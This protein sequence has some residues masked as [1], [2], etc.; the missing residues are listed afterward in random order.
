MTDA[1]TKVVFRF[2]IDTAPG[3]RNGVPR[4]LDLLSE[5]GVPATFYANMGRAVSLRA[6]LRN[7]FSGEGGGAAATQGKLTAR[8]KIGL[9][10]VLETL[11]FNPLVGASYPKVLRRAASLGHEMGLHGGRS[12]GLWQWGAYGLSIDQLKSEIRWGIDQLN[13][14]VGACPQGFSSPGWASPET[15][16]GII[17]SF[18]FSY[19]ADMHD[20]EN[21]GVLRD[22]SSGILCL[23]TNL[24][25]E[26]RGVGF[27]E[28]V[29]ARDGDGAIVRDVL[30]E[31]LR[32]FEHVV[33]YDHP[34][35]SGGAGID[36]VRVAL[37][38]CSETNARVMTASEM[39]ADFAKGNSRDG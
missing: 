17:E 13:H 21:E 9:A 1:R 33:L 23:N 34:A 14:A 19:L 5:F 22:P 4:L 29:A 2:D 37:E 35:F 26:P 3:I 6:T 10:G 15:L 27:F 28:S 16:P 25:G 32:L 24:A 20:P 38:T 36:L 12:H 30:R 8:Q 7:L 18:G 11:F 39:I 31:K